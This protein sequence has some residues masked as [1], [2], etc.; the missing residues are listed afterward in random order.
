VLEQQTRDLEPDERIWRREYAAIPQTGSLAVFEPEAIVRAFLPPAGVPKPFGRFGVIDASSGKKDAWTFGVAS[1]CDVAGKRQLVFDKIDGFDGTFFQQQSGEAIVQAVADC[2]KGFG[3]R[4]V[5]GDQREAFM[6]SS[7]FRRHGIRFTEL[8]WS[9]PNKERAVSVV[10]RWL[11]EDRLV[12]PEHEK[13]KDELLEFEERVTTSGAFTFGARGTGHDD[14]VALLITAAIA[15]SERRLSGSPSKRNNML[16]A[17]K[18]VG[19]REALEKLERAAGL[20]S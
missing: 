11:A 17:L 15:E 12:L 18:Q 7:A 10:R 14:Y 2:L 3:V 9:Q 13:M 8:P 20:R 4:H 6:V 16:E 5:I 19:A 1:W